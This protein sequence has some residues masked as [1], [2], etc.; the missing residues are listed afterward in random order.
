M[1]PALCVCVCF[2]IC[3]KKITSFPRSGFNVQP[4]I[5]FF[6]ASYRGGSFILPLNTNPSPN[7]GGT[8]AYMSPLTKGVGKAGAWVMDWGFRKGLET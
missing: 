5:Y 1:F 6:P 8:V 4:N 7:P 2:L 3:L